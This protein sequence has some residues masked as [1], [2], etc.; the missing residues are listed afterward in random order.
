MTKCNDEEIKMLNG[1]TCQEKCSILCQ[2]LSSPGEWRKVTYSEVEDEYTKKVLLEYE[3]EVELG[4]TEEV[5]NPDPSPVDLED[6]LVNQADY[7][8]VLI[9]V[10][11]AE[12]PQD[13]YIYVRAIE[14]Y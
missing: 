2:L 3:E 9:W 6:Y 11:R 4:S 10:R 5:P 8:D 12:T 13:E 7:E 14:R 1:T